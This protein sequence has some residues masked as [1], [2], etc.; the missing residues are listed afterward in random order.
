MKNKWKTF[1]FTLAFSALLLASFGIVMIYSASMV[2]AV[3]DGTPANHFM[4]R[5]LVWLCIG[6]I[7]FLF[8]SFFQYRFYQKLMKVI[9]FGLMFLLILV[10]FFGTAANNAR[11]WLA[12]GPMTMQ[13]SEFVK[14]GLIIYLSSIYSKKQRYI[15][16]FNKGVLPPLIIT[17]VLLGLIMLQPDIGTA[18][19]IFLIACSVIFSAGIRLRHLSML[20]VSGIGVILLAA[21]KMVT[22]E[23]IERF[24]GAYQPF[25]DPVDSGYQLIQ[26]YLA[27]GTGG[28][29]WCRTW[30]RGSKVRLLK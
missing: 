27:I 17:V 29:F 11:S 7:G 28:F 10:L 4:I 30:T 3:I 24:T 2:I 1:D 19:I 16:D 22:D 13:P 14:L 9:I 6:F 26:S 20:I 15:H 21:T 23:R 12:I 5:Q 25:S 8:C 18:A